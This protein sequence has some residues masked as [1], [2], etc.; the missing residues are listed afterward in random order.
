M[1]DKRN[2]CN[3]LGSRMAQDLRER[4]AASAADPD[5]VVAGSVQTASGS[6]VVATDDESSIEIFSCEQCR[7]QYRTKRGLGAHIAKAHPVA[8]NSAVNTDRVKA[9]WPVEEVRLMARA[10]AEATSGSG[11]LFMNQFLHDKF[12]GRSLEAIKGKRRQEAYREMVRV[13]CQEISNNEIDDGNRASPTMIRVGTEPVRTDVTYTNIDI[14]TSAHRS[15]PEQSSQRL[16]SSIL[17]AIEQS[18][19]LRSYQADTLRNIAREALRAGEV[20][21]DAIARWLDSIFPPPVV[22]PPRHALRKTSSKPKKRENREQRIKRLFATTQT[23][24]KRNLK[25]CLAHI[26]NQ[27]AT[28][29]RPSNVDLNRYWAPVM[30]ADSPAAGDM[31]ALRL[32]YGVASQRAG[33]SRSR[34]SGARGIHLEGLGEGANADQARAKDKTSLWDP[35]T[36]I[37]VE[38]ISVKTGTAPGLDQITPRMWNAVPTVLRALLFN[39]LLFARGVPESIATTRTVFLEK[40]GM[41]VRPSPS[42]YRPLS[43]GSVIIRQLHKI[44]A[45]RLAALEIIDERQRGFRPVD[46]VC[47]NVTVLS[48]VLGDARGRCRTLHLATVDLSKAFD[49]VSHKAIHATLEELEL[50]WEFREYV[51][52][53]YSN[54][55]TVLSGASSSSAIKIGRGVRQGDPLSPLLFNLVVDRA[56]GVLSEDVG[57]TMGGKRINALGYADDIVLL[58]ST[59]NGLQENLT[60]LHAAFSTN[61]LTINAKKT[62]VLSLV[63][64]GRDKKVK[65]DTIPHFSVGGVVIPQRSPVEVWTWKCI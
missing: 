42:E 50:P 18:T 6:R 15:A 52:A 48:A 59:R 14:D 38:R 33:T 19:S 54:A 31:T 29:E 56:L 40:S 23:L 11:V 1:S 62:G 9:R 24:Y 3:R 27:G 45:K 10:E 58:A 37:E 36:H 41:S 61:G 30:E 39:L 25:T 20:E 8:A 32:Q 60:R 46:G 49:T 26:L 44:L 65:V 5:G 51:R 16:R 2:K 21:F 53:V 7:T 12:P 4:N 22:R 57:Y 35:I 63:A 34:P 28:P 55:R 13:F 64:S 47:E 17:Q 43:I